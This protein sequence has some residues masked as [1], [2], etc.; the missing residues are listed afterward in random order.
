MSE[1]EKLT[2]LV[3]ARLSPTL[4]TRVAELVRETGASESDIVRYPLE[5]YWPETR[6]HFLAQA[7]RAEA[8][9]PH[10][11]RK[12]GEAARLG[13]N[14]EHVIASAIARAV[15]SARPDPFPHRD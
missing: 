3:R 13:I 8:V 5:A 11:M 14:V 2:E 15:C 12:I 10:L 1:R 4:K 9:E 6:Q 7:G